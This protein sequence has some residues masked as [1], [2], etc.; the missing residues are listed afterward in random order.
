MT[1]GLKR[2]LL[3]K[4][5]LL[6]WLNSAIRGSDVCDDCRFT[7]I[8]VNRVLDQDGCN[9]SIGNLRCSGQPAAVCEPIATRVVVKARA[10]FN[11]KIP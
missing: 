1:T 2:K 3:A 8:R 10:M 9:W 11:V 5:K 6:D 7:S 4:E